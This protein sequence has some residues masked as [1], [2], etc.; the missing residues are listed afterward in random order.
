ALPI[1]GSWAC[2]R[3]G[4]KGKFQAGQ[5]TRHAL[6]VAG[7]RRAAGGAVVMPGG[8][9]PVA[10]VP[11]LLAQQLGG[12][13]QVAGGVQRGA[14]AGEALTVVAPVDLREADVDTGGYGGAQ[15]LMQG[16]AGGGLAGEAQGSAGDVQRPGPGAQLAAQRQGAFL[17]GDGVED[18]GGNAGLLGDPLV[19]R[20]RQ[21]PRLGAAEQGQQEQAQS[22]RCHRPSRCWK[23]AGS[24]VS[25]PRRCQRPWS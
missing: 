5:V 11:V 9:Q 18:F 22:R 1:W 4:E 12:D 10:A 16:L 3:G 15:R 25:W 19:G 17:Q 6:P 8:L 23:L 14:G 24:C 13:A 21:L 7:G 20:R 2:L